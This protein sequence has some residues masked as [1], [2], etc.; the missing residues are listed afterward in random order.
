MRGPT[1]S[2]CPCDSSRKQLPVDRTNTTDDPALAPPHRAQQGHSY[3]EPVR[4]RIPRQYSLPGGSAAW[5]APSR[6]PPTTRT[7]VSGHAFPFT[8]AAD[9]T[10]V[11]YAGHH[12]AESGHRQTHPG[13]TTTGFDATL[14]VTTVTDPKTRTAPVFDPPD[15]SRAPSHRSP[16][17]SAT[18]QWLQP[19]PHGRR[20][21][22]NLIPA[23]PV[24]SI[25]KQSL[26]RNEAGSE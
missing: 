23:Y 22:P 17:V 21:R 26:R 7:A 9:R 18:Q 15:A 20:R 3:Y 19:P 11:A 8:K 25:Y 12:L 4:Q 14:L 10:H 1:A 6:H 13:L 5:Q 16:T 2:A 24:S